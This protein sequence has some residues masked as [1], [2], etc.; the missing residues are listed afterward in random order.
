MLQ[1]ANPVSRSTLLKA[2]LR[3][4]LTKAQKGLSRLRKGIERFVGRRP[5]TTVLLTLTAFVLWRAVAG[6]R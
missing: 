5:A 1:L 3:D 2:N 6:R 4:G